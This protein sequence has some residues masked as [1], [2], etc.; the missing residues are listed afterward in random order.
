MHLEVI[1]CALLTGK[2]GVIS[3]GVDVAS[4]KT[5]KSSTGGSTWTDSKNDHKSFL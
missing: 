1:V 2:V 4:H 3:N 5:A